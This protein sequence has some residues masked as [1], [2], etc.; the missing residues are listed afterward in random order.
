VLVRKKKDKIIDICNNKHIDRINSSN[1]LLYQTAFVFLRSEEIWNLFLYILY[2]WN[3][4]LSSSRF[5]CLFIANH[6]VTIW[7]INMINSHLINSKSITWLTYLTNDFLKTK[8]KSIHIYMM[9]EMSTL[10]ESLRILKKCPRI[11]F[12]HI[13][14]IYKRCQSQKSHTFSHH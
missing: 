2:H 1:L 7:R 14:S 12:I 10:A 6:I 11:H 13:T 9:K 3:S 5:V 8:K 4:F